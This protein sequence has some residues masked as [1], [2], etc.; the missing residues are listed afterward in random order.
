MSIADRLAIHDLVAEY[1][2][3]CDTGDFN[4]ISELF[5]DD[6][7]WDERVLGAPLCEGRD[8]I[9]GLFQALNDAEIPLV[10]HIT[11]ATSAS[12]NSTVTP[13]KARAT[14]AP[15][16]RSTASRWTCTATTTTNTSRSTANGGSPVAPWSPSSRRNQ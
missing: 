11:S 6:G 8:A 5:A 9:H 15:P 4:G 10:M 3:R 2:W 13:R 12:P 7:T 1:S 16:V 14:Y